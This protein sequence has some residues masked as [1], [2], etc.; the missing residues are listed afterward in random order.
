MTGA[1]W[2]QE[3][4]LRSLTDRED[5]L[6]WE[7]VG[8]LDFAG[9]G[10]CS[11]TLIAPDLVLTEAHCVYDQ[12]GTLREADQIRFRAG[13][14]NETA[15]AERQAVQLAAHEGYTPWRGPDT[16]NI[17][18]DVAL[19]RLVSPITSAEAVQLTEDASPIFRS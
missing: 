6:G 4:G 16:R 11:G 13:L 18:Y 10:F 5:L 1:A 14:Q 15:I 12:R 19:I 3:R 8:R 9:Q 2:A 7:A 17:T